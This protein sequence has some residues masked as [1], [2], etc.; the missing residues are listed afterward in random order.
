L[1]ETRPR[2]HL[3][4]INKVDLPAAWSLDEG[5][6]DAIEL[7]VKTGAG[8]GKLVEQMIAALGA[9][10]AMRDHPRVS[11]VR[12]IALLQ[13]A[14]GALTRARDAL[15]ETDAV[16]EEFVL[17]DLQDASGALQEITG[18]RTTDDLLSHIFERFCIGK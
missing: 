9:S 11:N 10:E 14:E 13:R 16:S 12:H 4:I 18:Q 1:L 15:K 2:R 7:S 6:T 17:A 8:L 5:L 3:V